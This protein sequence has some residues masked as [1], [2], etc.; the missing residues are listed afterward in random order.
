MSRP[1]LRV[2]DGLRE[3]AEEAEI[4]ATVIREEAQAHIA[5]MRMSLQRRFWDAD[6]FAPVKR[7]LLA[8]VERYER[9]ISNGGEAA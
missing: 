6:A 3:Q 1:S 2:I 8:E 4:E 5:R 9:R 7:A